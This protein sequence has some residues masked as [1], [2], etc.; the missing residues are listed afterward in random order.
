[1]STTAR[2]PR[3]RTVRGAALA[4]GVAAALTLS[5]CSGTGSTSSTGAAAKTLTFGIS[6]G[7]TS[8]DPT[9]GGNGIPLA[10][11]NNIAYEPLINRSV[12][13]KEEPGLATKWG[14]SADRLT[15]T[16]E[17][18]KGAKF[19]DG[20]SVTAAAVAG[21]LQHYKA[22]GNFT[23]WLANVKTITAT[24]DDTVTLK[25]SAPDPLL[26]YGLDQGGTAGNVVSPTGLKD[27]KALGRTTHGAG[28]YMLDPKQTIANSS[29]VYVKN[30]NYYDKSK[31]YWNKVVVKVITDSNSMLSALRSGQV[32][33]AQGTAANAAAAKAAGITV[34]S[35]PTAFTG[36][37]LGDI[38]GTITPAFK[39]VRVRQALNYAID[40]KSI[41]KTV[42][43]EYGTATDQVVAKGIGGYEAG[44]EDTYPYDPA[45]A[46]ALLKDA[47]YPNGFGFTLIEQPG[48]DGGDLLAQAMVAQWKAI[49]VNVKLQSYS[50]F[51]DYVTGL[52]SKKFP[53]TT[54]NFNY[55]AQLVATQ[56]LVTN[57]ALYNYMGYTD[58]KA[59]Q[60]AVEQRKQDVASPEGVAAAEASEKYIVDG[61]FVVPVTSIS[62]QIFS[63]KAV[64]GVD[65]TSYPVPDPRKWKPAN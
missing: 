15:F 41:S 63:T 45:K 42:Y 5:A 10:W 55:S 34:T 3:G 16:L 30:P 1:M 28:P 65:F 35:A 18:R 13:G 14:Y 9:S 2:I 56:E 24:D 31:Q 47:G 27:E 51:A 50:S 29:Y 7:P 52:T 40:R 19:S 64:T 58:K 22:K 11:Y 61:A 12:D 38:D 44:L 49:G 6:T 32:Q 57:P 39:D 20:D 60:L 21:W 17:L 54:L 62:G 46:K 23:G 43:G 36:V 59:N 48:V 8:L 37:Y 4:M 25:L 26:T 33:V 53:A